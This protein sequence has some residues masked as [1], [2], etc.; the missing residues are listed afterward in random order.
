M[1]EFLVLALLPV[2]FGIALG[3]LTGGRLVEVAGRFRALW[4]LWLACAVQALQMRALLPVVF[5]IGLAWLVVNLRA[6]PS[7]LRWAGFVALTGATCNG[8]AIALNG[9]MP[10]SRAAAELVGVPP[11]AATSK[12]APA[13]SDTRL[14]FLGD[15][16]P[17]PALHKIVSVG[18]VLIA[19]GVVLLLALAMQP[20]KSR[21]EVM[22]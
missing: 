9:R 14:L 17:V 11:G 18:D 19:L 22:G 6:W 15:V 5:A 16:I 2:V 1:A 20:V 8:I 4:L 12:N 3:H 21:K 7:S 10:Y 13:D